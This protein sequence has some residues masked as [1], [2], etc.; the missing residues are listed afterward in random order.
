MSIP[1]YKPFLLTFWYSPARSMRRLLDLNRGH[2]YA[3]AIAAFF[4][5][6]QFGRLL[7]V[8][9]EALPLYL[10]LCGLGGIACLFLF[11]WLV[12]NFGRWFGVEAIQREVRTA[13]A[14]GILPWTLIFGILSIILHLGYSPESIVADYF[15]VVLG[16]F[17]Y[18][19]YILLFSLKAALRVGVITT[20]LCLIVATAL[21][22]F[23]LALLAQFLASYLN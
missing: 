11:S 5:V 21:S 10:S 14:M 15:P 18:G 3:L 6:I 17:I 1:N 22:F 20:F 19:F 2:F 13:L 16:V 4:G 7:P 23:P 8:K 9:L 12:C